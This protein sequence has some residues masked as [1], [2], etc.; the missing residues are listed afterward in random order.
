[1]ETVAS[2]SLRL[3][4]TV[5]A[6]LTSMSRY[7]ISVSVGEPGGASTSGSGAG[8]GV[9]EWEWGQRAGLNEHADMIAAGTH[10][11]GY[12]HRGRGLFL[13]LEVWVCDLRVPDKWPRWLTPNSQHSV[14]PDKTGGDTAGGLEVEEV[15][16][17]LTIALKIINQS[18]H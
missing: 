14:R 6:T 17:G 13:L 4:E 18:S 8:S 16:P 11:F 12:R 9:C 15:L 2:H 3:A 10:R 5:S 1:M 7:T